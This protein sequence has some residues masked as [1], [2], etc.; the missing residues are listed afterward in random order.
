MRLL[1]ADEAVVERLSDIEGY[2]GALQEMFRAQA[3]GTTSLPPRLVVQVPEHEASLF[4][5]P[6]FMGGSGALGAKLITLFPHN[7]GVRHPSHQG[8]ILL[9]DPR[10]GHLLAEFEA[11]T[12]TALRTA[13][14]SG[15]ATDLLARRDVRNLAIL[16]SGRQARSH[17]QV[18]L[19]VRKF[20]KVQVWSRSREHS[21]AFRA[22]W[23]SKYPDILIEVSDTPRGAVEGADVVCTTT[24]TKEPIVR[25]QWIR[26]GTHL[27]CVG[28]AGKGAREIDTDLVSKSLLFTDR[29]ESLLLEGGD[30]NAAKS[31][32]VVGDSHIRGEL[33]DLLL[34]NVK[35][36]QNPDEVTLYRGL[37]TATEDLAVADLLYH[38]AL[39]T[40]S[41]T[42]VEFGKL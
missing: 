34:G 30:F 3:K 32:G 1:L 14:A 24:G 23:S 38:R 41:G 20:E 36:R 28:Y 35:G 2:I 5:M 27:N 7:D 39:A 13:C 18:M 29:V 25:G 4:A 10:D 22:E 6:G 16:G 26:P 12:I 40:D 11:A 9:F 21:E 15:I 37:G 8:V 33:G 31:E 19:H 17:L 42:W